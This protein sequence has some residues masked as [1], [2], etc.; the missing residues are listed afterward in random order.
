[1]TVLMGLHM[2]NGYQLKEGHVTGSADNPDDDPTTPETDHEVG[3]SNADVC[4]LRESPGR[5]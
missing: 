2:I 1:M 5:L 4:R 3:L